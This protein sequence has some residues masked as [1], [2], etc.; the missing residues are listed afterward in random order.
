[1]RPCIDLVMM[2]ILP[3]GLKCDGNLRSLLE[4]MVRD[5]GMCRLMVFWSSYLIFGWSVDKLCSVKH[6]ISASMLFM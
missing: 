2:F 3:P 4:R 5:E 6:M 1:M